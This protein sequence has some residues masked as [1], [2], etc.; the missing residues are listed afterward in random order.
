MNINRIQYT[1]ISFLFGLIGRIPR[2]HH[3][4]LAKLLGKYLHTLDKKHRRIVADNL[5]QAFG[6]TLSEKEI[7]ILARAVFVHLARLLFEIGWFTRLKAGNLPDT[8]TIEGLEH[9]R[10]ALAKNRG[11]F[12]LTA[13]LGNW[14]LLPVATMLG[15]KNAGFVYRPLDTKPLDMFFSEQRSRFGAAMIPSARA[16][17]KILRYIKGKGTMFLLM[18]Q[19]VDWYEGVFVDFFG[20]RACTNKGLALMA[21]KTEAPVLPVFMIRE[22]QGF[23]L[24]FGRE[25]PLI[26]T[27]DKTR[28]VEE[29][30]RQYNKTL[31]AFIC[32]YPD[33][34][35]WV[36]QRWKTR[37]YCMLTDRP[38][39][40]RKKQIN[41]TGTTNGNDRDTEANQF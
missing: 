33:Q 16:M 1:L 40:R 39:G 4:P 14:E 41:H 12:A 7:R 24:V 10:N 29:N 9:Y 31:E 35:F 28:D 26:K 22:S 32:R 18:D 37:P 36:H 27:G 5:T 20:S 2:Q 11:V 3:L 6:H 30:T 8:F 17:R 25:I 23:K 19:N 15:L 13:H 21:L 34:W 38:H